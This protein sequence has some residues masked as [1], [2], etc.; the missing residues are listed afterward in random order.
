MSLNV[1]EFRKSNASIQ[2]ATMNK[3]FPVV[4]AVV[5][6]ALF[7]QTGRVF[8]DAGATT[9][10][11]DFTVSS[12]DIKKEFAA[13]ADAASKKYTGKIVRVAGTVNSVS[14]FNMDGQYIF[15]VDGMPAIRCTA[16]AA[17]R[18][19]CKAIAI[20]QDATV[21]GKCAEATKDKFTLGD[22]EVITAGKDPSVTVSAADLA[23]AFATKT[24]A[25]DYNGEDVT[26]EGTVSEVK[27]EHYQVFL[28]GFKTAEGKTVNVKCMV[29]ASGEGDAK[30]LKKGSKVVVKGRCTGIM[31]GE[32]VVIAYAVIQE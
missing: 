22:C 8:A 21:Q 4:V 24:G 3:F 5:A 17:G 32:D 29:G 1:S 30:K 10:P 28:D 7:A 18:K 13:D 23:K 16:S 25:R 27:I 19:D 15:T 20:G 26:V 2:G 11:A 12:A 14:E 6:L 31:D 9:K